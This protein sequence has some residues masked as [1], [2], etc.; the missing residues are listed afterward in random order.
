MTLNFKISE[1][2]HSDIANMYHINN[3]TSNPV[4]LDNMLNLIFYVL[5]P[6]RD[7]VKCPVII[8]GGY[9]SQDLWQKLHDLG[10]NPAKNSQHLTGQAADINVP[11]KY[12][13]EVFKIIREQLPYDQLLYEYDLQGH[14]WIHVSYNHGKNR[15][16]A[17]DNYKAY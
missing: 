9:R 5:Q 6:L 13:H 7:I 1:L 8:T 3:T 4:H 14:R 10:K 2:L 15:K 11:Q 12:L 16:H 17:I